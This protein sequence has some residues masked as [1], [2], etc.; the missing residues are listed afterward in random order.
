VF[1]HVQLFFITASGPSPSARPTSGTDK[2]VSGGV[3]AGGVGPIGD[4]DYTDIPNTQIR[5]VRAHCMFDLH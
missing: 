5:R 2:K 1:N 3:P 4:V